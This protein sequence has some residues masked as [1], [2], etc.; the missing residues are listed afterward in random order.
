[1]RLINWKKNLDKKRLPAWLV[2]KCIKEFLDK[3]LESKPLLSTVLKKD[4]VT[5]LP[6]LGKLSLQIHTRIKSLMKSKL[7]YY[8]LW[9][10]FRTKCK[11]NN[12]CI[13]KDRIPLFLRST[14]LYKFQG[15]GCNATYYQKPRYHFKMGLHEN[16]G[17]SAFTG[18]WVDDSETKQ[19]FLFC[20]KLHDFEELCVLTK[21][22]SD[23]KVTLMGILLINRE[24]PN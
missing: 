1:M 13:S 12:F 20:S 18:K 5:T 6:C 17:I 3:K 14:I 10:A 2:D 23:F 19:H 16:L 22:N 8:Y 9:F 15:G 21:N 7:P 24:C 11:I 4:L